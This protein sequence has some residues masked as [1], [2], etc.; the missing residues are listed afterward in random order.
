MNGS[1]PHHRP[2]R[3]RKNAI[4]LAVAAGLALF[5]LFLTRPWIEHPIATHIGSY[6]HGN[7]FV[8]SDYMRALV[9]G[10]W[11]DFAPGELGVGPLAETRFKMFPDGAAYGVSFDGL[12][13]ALVTAALHWVLPLCS[14]MDLALILA[15]VLS[16]W[17][18][19]Q[20]G[21]RLWG[22]GAVALY[23][24]F[25]A[26][27]LPYLTQR[28]AYHPNLTYI[29]VI[30]L[31]MHLFFN[32][33]ARPT[34]KRALVFGGVT[35]PLLAA[36]SWYVLVM[37]LAFFSALSLGLGVERW[38]RRVAWRDPAIR[39]ALGWCVAGLG[40]ALVAWPMLMHARGRAMAG[41]ED[42]NMF[43][44]PLVQYLMP[45]PESALGHKVWAQAI[46]ARIGTHWEGMAGGPIA[47]ILLSCAFLAGLGPR[48]M[49]W[50]MGMAA[51][52][53]LTLTCGPHLKIFH[54]QPWDE[55]IGLPLYW[56]QKISSKFNN[57]RHPG[58]MHPALMY[59]C[60]VASGVALEHGLWRART[61]GRRRGMYLFIGAALAMNLLWSVR[62][63][64]YPVYPAISVPAWYDEAACPGVDP[65]RRGAILDAPASHYYF[66]IYDY[67]QFTH[68]RPVM[69]ASGFYHDALRP[70]NLRFFDENPLMAF[71][72]DDARLNADLLDDATTGQIADPAFLAWLSSR[73]I[74][75]VVVHPKLLAFLADQGVSAPGLGERYA[76]IERAWAERLV[77]E[78]SEIRVYR[79]ARE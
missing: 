15:F 79:T 20:M 70:K 26:A 29:W 40:V 37:G 68:G 52:V 10:G 41:P 57:I 34:L 73:G 53:M 74:E 36:S 42:L 21:R 62:P 9:F 1:T 30:P 17:F 12:L 72:W 56:L 32:F 8:G 61:P 19:W 35:F 14:A 77:F 67:Y 60:I 5:A 78:D 48:R 13:L 3:L 6:D 45:H 2:G 47:A 69:S 39:L 75:Y 58:R 31:G 18:T 64:Y 27:C 51:F 49:R 76:Q 38:R 33:R 71:F 63:G 7:A 50:P 59:A 54:A 4:D 24:A 65:A 44:V 55:G 43:S 25:T 11:I 28:V 46:Q 66:S 23:A 16:G 22:R